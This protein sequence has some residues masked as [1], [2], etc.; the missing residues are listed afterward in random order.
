LMCMTGSEKYIPVG[1]KAQPVLDS[2]FDQRKSQLHHF[3]IGFQKP[4]ICGGF[5]L[6]TLLTNKVNRTK[7]NVRTFSFSFP[8]IY[9]WHIQSMIWY[10]QFPQLP[11]TILWCTTQMF[12]SMKEI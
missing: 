5:S 9:H 2:I 1:T 11:R 10:A 12:R 4:G 7:L 8:S 6:I 3:T